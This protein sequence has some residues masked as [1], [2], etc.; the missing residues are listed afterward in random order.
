VV[1]RAREERTI[2]C[3][4]YFY[5]GQGR[6]LRIQQVKLLA[7]LEANS[8]AWSDGDFRTG[9]RVAAN[10]GLAGADIEY[11]KA[12]QLNPVARSKRFLQAFK[13]RID[14]RFRFVA[15]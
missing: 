13:D 6:G 5:I 3:G 1:G 12:S 9:P 10:P 11:P 2:R 14:S 15:R 8:L 7:R 4:R